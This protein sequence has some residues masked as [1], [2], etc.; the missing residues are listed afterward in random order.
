[1]STYRAGTQ[2]AIECDVLDIDGMPID[3]TGIA[4]TIQPGQG[5]EERTYTYFV[6][7][8]G[9]WTRLGVGSFRFLVDTAGGAGQY[10]CQWVASGNVEVTDVWVFNVVS[11]PL[12]A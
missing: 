1:M 10:T 12:G 11:P 9:G 2:V 8:T 4:V 7:G 3:P 6:S 5:Q